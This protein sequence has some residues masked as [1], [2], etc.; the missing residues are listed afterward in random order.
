MAVTCI[1]GTVHNYTWPDTIKNIKFNTFGTSVNSCSAGT[2]E[3]IVTD[4]CGENDSVTISVAPSQTRHAEFTATLKKGCTNANTILL[5]AVSND[6]PS[7][8]FADAEI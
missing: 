5:N 8:W 2:Y 3:L 6:N 7:S 1:D 4:T